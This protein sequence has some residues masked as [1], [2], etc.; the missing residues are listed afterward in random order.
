M[1]EQ[2]DGDTPAIPDEY[3]SRGQTV[4][5]INKTISDAVAK[6]DVPQ[7]IVGEITDQSR[8]RSGHIY[9]DLGDPESNDT[10]NCVIFQYQADSIKMPDENTLVAVTGSVQY[11]EEQGQVS[12]IVS[13]V[14]TITQSEWE[15]R[16]QALIEQFTEEGLFDETEKDPI[17]RLPQ[18]IGVVTSPDG[19]AIE[20]VTDTIKQR[21]PGVDIVVGGASVQGEKAT[22]QVM[23][24]V[25]QLDEMPAIGTIVI[26]RGGGSDTVLRVFDREPVVRVIA[27]ADT[28]TCV[29]I[30]HEDDTTLAER[31]SDQPAKTPT[32]AGRKVTPQKEELQ[33]TRERLQERLS[34]EYAEQTASVNRRLQKALAAA[35]TDR[36]QS[37]VDATRTDIVNAY[38]GHTQQQMKQYSNELQVAYRDTR[39]NQLEALRQ[40]LD[41]AYIAY[42]HNREMEAVTE[43][44]EQL[45]QQRERYKRVA[46][47]LAVVGLAIMGIFILLY[48]I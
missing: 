29:A 23:A 7:Y 33:K 24:Q 13:D 39:Q 35:Y 20:D 46:I 27:G 37:W 31:V 48:V 41:N 10:L 12:V 36:A 15:Q 16:R 38:T 22:E 17:P 44:T 32:A 19:S 1:S 11:Y 40:R 45:R 8:S 28:P 34:T 9:F 2:G 26:T 6:V 43:Q 47:A 30:G 18:T 4:K 42:Q 5:V 21:Y 14:E 25:K 3:K